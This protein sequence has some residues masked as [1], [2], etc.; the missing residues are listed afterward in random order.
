MTA[1]LWIRQLLKEEF[2]RHRLIP[3]D[4]FLQQAV[5]AAFEELRKHGVQEEV[6]DLSL[7]LKVR[8]IVDVLISVPDVS[9]GS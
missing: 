1:N 5:Y 3:Q 8:F 9:F 7:H 2:T 4:E 6:D